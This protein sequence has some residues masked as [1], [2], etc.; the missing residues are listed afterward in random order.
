MI[1]E[2]DRQTFHAYRDHRMSLQMSWD[3]RLGQ[4]G[5]LGILSQVLFGVNC[6]AIE[7]ARRSMSLEYKTLEMLIES[8]EE[9]VSCVWALLRVANSGCAL[10]LGE[11]RSCK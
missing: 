10:V 4:G 7:R 9:N 1:K 8:A 3:R 2:K 5:N 11:P 6:I